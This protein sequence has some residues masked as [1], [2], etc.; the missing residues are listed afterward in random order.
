MKKFILTLSSAFCLILS[1]CAYNTYDYEQSDSLIENVDIPQVETI[2]VETDDN[3]PTYSIDEDFNDNDEEDYDYDDF[4]DENNDLSS[5]LENYP[6]RKNVKYTKTTTY[7]TIDSDGKKNTKKQKTVQTYITNS[8]KQNQSKIFDESVDMDKLKLREFERERVEVKTV[9]VKPVVNTMYETPTITNTQAKILAQNIQDEDI[10]EQDKKYKDP[11]IK[12]LME[13]YTNITKASSVCCVSNLA[14]KLRDIGVNSQNILNILKNDARNF[15]VQDT[16][17]ILSNED[18]DD[19]FGKNGL[20][21][22]VKDTRKSCICAN[23]NFM[24]KNIAS[25]Y[26]IYNQDPDFYK[27][28]LLYRYRDNQSRITEHDVNETILN[29]A[30]TLEE[31]P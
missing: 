25:F 6:S 31:C 18:I 4:D 22:I 23:K 14:G 19:V 13:N 5:K 29:I 27:K 1:S 15:Y 26:K 12:N 17:L 24:R 10:I 28:E 21:K 7:S 3:V 16:C 8:G 20:S 11:N 30:L 2:E 9:L